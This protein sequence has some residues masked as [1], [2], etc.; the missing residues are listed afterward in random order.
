MEAK[1][2]QVNKFKITIGNKVFDDFEKAAEWEGMV[3]FKGPAGSIIVDA[4]IKGFGEL[5]EELFGGRKKA[6]DCEIIK[7]SPDFGVH[8]KEP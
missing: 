7:A 1:I 2:E 5:F 6:Q 3:K 8:L 4:G